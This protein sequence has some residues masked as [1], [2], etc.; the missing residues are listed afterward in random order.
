[1]MLPAL[2]RLFWKGLAWI[3]GIDDPWLLH[4]WHAANFAEEPHYLTATQVADLLQVHPATVYRLASADAT[5]PALRIG[6]AVRFPRE[7]LLRW[8][9]DRE[10][11]R[12]NRAMHSDIAAR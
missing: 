4:S 12:S 9:R 8:L 11:G 2:S 5:M 10:Q 7:R 3:Q 1:M 6:G